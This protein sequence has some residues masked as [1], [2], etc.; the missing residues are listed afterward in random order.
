MGM[1]GIDES[2]NEVVRN[3]NYTQR[4]PFLYYVTVTPYETEKFRKGLV[5]RW[6]VIQ[7]EFKH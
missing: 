4:R 5:Y 7:I 1:V 2:I 3:Y 6:A